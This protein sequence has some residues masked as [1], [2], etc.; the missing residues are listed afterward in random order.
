MVDPSTARVPHHPG[1]Q[2]PHQ[3]DTHGVPTWRNPN[4]STHLTKILI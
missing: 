3:P 1:H 4:K 2:D